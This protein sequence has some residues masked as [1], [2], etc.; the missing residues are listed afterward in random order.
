MGTLVPI[1][2]TTKVMEVFLGEK[3]Q[4]SIDE[5]EK[6]ALNYVADINTLKGRNECKAKAAGIA[7]Q[8]VVIEKAKKEL[9]AD[10]LAKGKRLDVVWNSI[11]KRMDDIRD[12]VRE[13]LTK[14]EEEKAR[15]DQEERE[16]IQF[17][18]EWDE[19]LEMNT[20]VDREREVAKKEAALQAAEDAR[21]AKEKAAQAEKDRIDREARIAIEAKEKAER[22]AKE[23]IEKAEREK[24]EA[25]EKAKIEKEQAIEDARLAK[26]KAEREK[27]EAIEK[28]Q[29]EERERQ[30]EIARIAEEKAAK[31]K[32]EADRKAKHKSHQKKIHREIIEDM[33][34]LGFSEKDV[35]EF[36]KKAA[37]GQIRNIVIKY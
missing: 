35:I 6:D 28:A 29:R 19:A 25:E 36:I 16:R 5:I 8:K 12:K 23:A 21:L 13:P 9:K 14:W 1:T 34:K 31:E 30:K 3:L 26:E 10:Y 32:T 24:A 33:G 22:E 17:E 27:K 20:L 37:T 4:E 18:L 2:D 7:K 15:K 11:K